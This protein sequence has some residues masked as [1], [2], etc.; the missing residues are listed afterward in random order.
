LL[1][2]QLIAKP[3]SRAVAAE[4]GVQKMHPCPMASG[5]LAVWSGHAAPRAR[6]RSSR[7]WRWLADAR[8]SKRSWNPR[9][10]SRPWPDQTA[11][12][13]GVHPHPP[14]FAAL[15]AVGHKE[16][17]PRHG[18]S[19]NRAVPKLA[20]V[21]RVWSCICRVPAVSRH[22]PPD[23]RPSA[24]SPARPPPAIGKPSPST[25]GKRFPKPQARPRR[26][27]PPLLANRPRQLRS[28]SHLKNFFT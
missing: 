7:T 2:P 18:E 27:N 14:G 17:K 11:E 26:Q 16:A 12:A 3:R 25:S 19:A 8:A 6:T 4:R 20:P 10:V 28:E 21:A 23:S 5:R 9:R 24:A 1:L 13:R 22:L 15:A